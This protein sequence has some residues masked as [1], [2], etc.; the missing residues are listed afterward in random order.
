M[1]VSES[2]LPLT[3]LNAG[4]DT[5]RLLAS[6][7]FAD[8]TAAARHLRSLAGPAPEDG[9][10]ARLLPHL[11]ASL[12]GAANP[13]RALINL[14]R[15]AQAVPDRGALLASLAADP[16]ALDL[17]VTIFAGSQF[18]TDILLRSPEHYADLVQRNTIGQ[19][20]S[21]AQYYVESY[22]AACGSLAPG[23][24]VCGASPEALDRLRKYQ[25]WELLRIGA[26]DL[27]GLLDLATV[28]AQLS[29]LADSVIW[30]CLELLAR[31]LGLATAG[32]V[33]LGMGKLGGGELN[34]S[35]DVDLLF[36][37]D[38]DAATFQRLGER[39][40]RALTEATAEGFLYRV[41]MRLRP[42]GRAGPLIP[43]VD[44]YLTYLERNARLWEKQ[45]LLRARVVAGDEQ[46][47]AGFLRRAE[48]LL[49]SGGRRGGHR[50]GAR[51]GARR[52]ARD[53]AT[54]RVAPAPGRPHLGRGQAGRR[55]DPR[56]RVCGAI[57]ATGL[58]QQPTGAPHRSHPGSPGAAG[59]ERL[60]HKR[61]LSCPDGRL[62]LSA[63]RR[64]LSANPGLPADPHAAGQP[65]RP[66]LPGAAA[67]L[68]RPG[69]RRTLR[70]AHP[71]TQR[72]DP[73]S[74]SAPSKAGCGWQ[75]VLRAY[76]QRRAN[77]TRSCDHGPGT[78]PG[79]SRQGHDFQ[80]AIGNQPPSRAAF[81]FLRRDVQ[82]RGRSRF[83]PSW[84]PA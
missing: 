77:S 76:F 17:L 11:R 70:G 46:A 22:R 36:L 48:P 21:P 64:T 42:W 20:K 30:V 43:T 16:H 65:R 5:R 73:C 35:S 32:F 68:R 29:H 23:D 67:G 19:A 3:G 55:L 34:Y 6:I 63:H 75:P 1:D 25:H 24:S 8:R 41:D 50:H 33:V 58:R 72:R 2:S 49:F 15:F 37:A 71:A 57:P 53:E 60:P 39:L 40:I 10:V 45:A 13:D 66:A 61:R 52:S 7:D 31:D 80:P 27:A 56:R 12:A 69:R 59:R 74:L 9:A 62:H 51:V 47:G 78:D 84:P 38:E 83:M 4:E 26:C 82:P 28:T 18:L 81:P 44:G 54:D 14:E 79:F